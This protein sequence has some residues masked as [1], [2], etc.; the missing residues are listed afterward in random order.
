M[1]WIGGVRCDKFYHDFVARTF[2]LVARFEPSFVR[3]GNGPECSQAAKNAPT[4]EFRVEWGGSGA[5]VAKISN[6]P[7]SHELLH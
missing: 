6:T 1:G 7:S 2:A 4:Q 5:F 3:Q